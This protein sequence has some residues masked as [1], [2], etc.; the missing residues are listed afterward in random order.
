MKEATPFHHKRASAVSKAP[1][2]ASTD[3]GDDDN[4]SDADA[5]N[6]VRTTAADL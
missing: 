6:H 3:A 2:A 1:A 5:R 4:D